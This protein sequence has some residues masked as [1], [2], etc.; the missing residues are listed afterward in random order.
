MIWITILILI[1]GAAFLAQWRLVSYMNH[2][3]TSTDTC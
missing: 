2:L 1:A 3:A